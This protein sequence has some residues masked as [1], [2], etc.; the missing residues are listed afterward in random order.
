MIGHPFYRYDWETY[1]Q[2]RAAHQP[3]QTPMALPTPLTIKAAMRPQGSPAAQPT[4]LPTFKPMKIM[5]FTP[6]QR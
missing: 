4:Q 5:N 1:S 6:A 2:R 3:A